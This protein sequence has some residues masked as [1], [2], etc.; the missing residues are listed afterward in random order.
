M[1]SAIGEWWRARVPG[2]VNGALFGAVTA[3]MAGQSWADPNTY[4]G[5]H[6]VV[7]PYPDIRGLSPD[8]ISLACL[9]YGL[10]ITAFGAVLG[11]LPRPPQVLITTYLGLPALWQ[12]VAA[13]ARYV[14]RPRITFL[15]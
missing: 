5:H 1:G 10:A 2:M 11:L 3:V 7:W 4:S 15:D 9:T 14:V 13:A 12:R 6:G 8:E